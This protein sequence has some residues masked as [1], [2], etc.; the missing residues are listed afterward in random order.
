MARRRKRRRRIF[1]RVAGM[2]LFLGILAGAAAAA[3]HVV[4]DLFRTAKE[5]VSLA[6]RQQVEFP[7]L[8]VSAEEVAGDF[9][10]QQLS[11]KEQT[12]YRELL[13]GVN[14]MEG[15]IRLHAGESD[16]AGKVYE[17]LLYDRPELF[18][19][20]GSS[21]MTIYE[22]YTEMSPGYT[23]TAEEKE[24]RQAQ[25]ETE[26]QSCLAGIDGGA[27]DYEKIKYVYEYIVDTVDYDETVPDNQ[28]IYSS[29]AKKRSVCAGY[30]RMAQ[31]L[32]EK[33][34]IPCIYVIGTITGQGAHAWNIVNCDGKYYQMDTTFGD[35][36]FLSAESREN[37]PG[38]SI[39]YDYLC[40]TDEVILTDH[41]PDDFVSY[42]ACTSDDLDYYKLNGMYYENY[43][44]D[45]LLEDMR[46]GIYAGE[47][48]FVCKFTD[49]ADYDAAHD[50]VT[51][52]LLPQAAQ[53][54][55]SYYGLSTVVYTYAEDDVHHKITVFW[56]YE[57]E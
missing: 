52:S 45:A 41:E 43:D 35:P 3:G 25:I 11:E 18:W 57:E 40:C 22:E 30:S 36:V 7:E 27:S 49:S 8:T 47:E 46:E 15:V 14:G 4:P 17:Y 31:Y 2:V 34:G 28:N 54:L 29:M 44:A 5:T 38:S 56:S 6:V 37:I 12:I 33:L 51:G 53:A 21:S 10:Y 50:E 24:A 20:D 42:P 23:C 9:Y 19:C 32:L 16:D 26:T 1:P 39:N 48:T 13:Q 55:A